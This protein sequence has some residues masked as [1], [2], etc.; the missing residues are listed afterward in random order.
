MNNSVK[1]R[2]QALHQTHHHYYL[3]ISVE[4]ANLSDWW[5]ESNRKNRFGSENRIETFL[6]ELECS[7]IY[8]WQWHCRPTIWIMDA[9]AYVLMLILSVCRNR[10]HAVKLPPPKKKILPDS[11]FITMEFPLKKCLQRRFHRPGLHKKKCAIFLAVCRYKS[12]QY[13]NKWEDIWVSY[14]TRFSSELC[15]HSWADRAGR[16]FEWKLP[17]G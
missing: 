12:L 7:T 13:H 16:A 17:S 1:R 6:P 9:I 8:Y 5:I 10:Y 11:R 4:A 3:N 15:K 2:R 14:F